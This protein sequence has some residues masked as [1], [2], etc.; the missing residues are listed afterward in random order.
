MAAGELEDQII[1]VYGV[2]LE[3]GAITECQVHGYLFSELDDDAFEQAKKIARKNP[4][5]GLSPD[6]AVAAVEDAFYDLGY[7]CQ[8]CAKNEAE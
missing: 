1:W 5:I 3:A 2:L 7:E 8:G 4:W 6:E